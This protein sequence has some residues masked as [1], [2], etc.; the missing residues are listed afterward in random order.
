MDCMTAP[1]HPTRRDFLR[2]R[3]AARQSQQDEHANTP[4]LLAPRSSLLLS[5][6]RRAMACEFEVQLP[7]GRDDAMDAVLEALDLVEVLEAQMTIY[8]A[9]SEVILSLIHI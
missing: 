3:A 4:S 2:G 8:R 9:D 7:A 1:N 5:V 6:R